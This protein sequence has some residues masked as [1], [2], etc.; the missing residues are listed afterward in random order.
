[1][2]DSEKID[3]LAGQ[4]DAMLVAISALFKTHPDLQELDKKLSANTE[5]QVTTSLGRTVTE[6]YLRGQSKG[7]ERIRSLL[8]AALIQK[9]G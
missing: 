8:E 4:L 3:Y 7:H 9:R 1:M 5:L 6:Q 2:T